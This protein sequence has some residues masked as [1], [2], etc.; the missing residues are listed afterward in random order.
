MQPAAQP[1]P[2]LTP[3]EQARYDD[4]SEAFDYRWRMVT[5]LE[6]FVWGRSV[7]MGGWAGT[8]RGERDRG[9]ALDTSD[10]GVYRSSPSTA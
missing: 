2:E 9:T 8:P 6:R 1:A 4:Y 10:G 5:P 7:P 3:F